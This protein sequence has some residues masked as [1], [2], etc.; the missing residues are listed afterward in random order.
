M[1][2]V[3]LP[4]AGRVFVLT[5]RNGSGKTR[6]LTSFATRF[7]EH[8]GDDAR[9]LICLSGTVLDKFPRD[10]RSREQYAYFGRRINNNM[11]SE[12][13]PYRSL[14]RYI[15]MGS[16]VDQRRRAD[17]A[18]ALFEEIGLG[19]ELRL[20]FRR[21][22][23]SRDKIQD[24]PEGELD[25]NFHL[26][27]RF[28]AGIIAERV[29]Q[30]AKGVIHLSAVGFEKKERRVDL[31]D[32]SSGERNS[33]LALLALAFCANDGA[34][35]LFDEPENSLHPSWQSSIIRNMWRVISEVSVGSRLVVATHSPLIASGA[36]NR[37]TYVLNMESSNDWVHSSLYGS[38]SD[39]VLKQQFG[40]SS[41]RAM[42]FVSLVR[43]CLQA[44]VQ[45]ELDPASF[46]QAADDLMRMQVRLDIDDPLYKTMGHI[47]TK[48]ESM[49]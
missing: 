25:V 16:A 11:F 9:R 40:L 27:D 8:L 49:S 14:L 10:P 42:S 22:R 1:I 31:M 46:R 45:V 13:S 28:T 38:D 18:R 12:I 20:R 34:T 4:W 36:S 6:W 37:E 44:L 5:G 29:A 43:D 48:R 21:G 26:G 7:L 39:T 33:A 2:S 32:L 24:G 19:D 47:V 30:L 17:T 23:N 35:V 3:E 41:S 15:P